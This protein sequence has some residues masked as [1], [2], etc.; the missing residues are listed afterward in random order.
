MSKENILDIAHTQ[1][2]HIHP[3]KEI[4]T[5]KNIIIRSDDVPNLDQHFVLIHETQ[6]ELQ[7]Q[8]HRIETLASQTNVDLAQLYTRSRSNNENLNKLLK[9]VVDYS[10]EVITEGNAT[11]ADMGLIMG[12]LH[13]LKSKKFEFGDE[14]IN[15]VKEILRQ[16]NEQNDLEGYA[17]VKREI[18]NMG[19]KIER[20]DSLAFDRF[21]KKFEIIEQLLLA[22]KREGEKEKTN[23]EH[24]YE[25]MEELKSIVS[26]EALRQR[27]FE[28]NMLQANELVLEKLAESGR[29]DTSSI[30]NKNDEVL[31][32]LRIVREMLSVQNADKNDL[33]KESET[34]LHDLQEKYLN[35]EKQYKLLGEKMEL[36]NQKY[37]DKFNQ[38]KLLLDK[39]EQLSRQVEEA[40]SNEAPKLHI[41]NLRKFHENAIRNIESQESLKYN[42]RIVS[43]PVTFSNNSDEE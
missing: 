24:I 3:L 6:E 14:A 43:T 13:E 40:G 30:L 22:E 9:N 5:N 34:Q 15:S 28:Q 35:L 18:E 27:K 32:L 1:Q 29:P 37:S 41:L 8:L 39:F 25:S 42:K 10:E 26:E 12:T 11:K 16:Y 20:N 4:S 2:S 36:L 23:Y 7:T 38:Y 33:K 17:R 21:Y 19:N 31:E